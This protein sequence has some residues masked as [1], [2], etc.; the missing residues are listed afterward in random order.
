MRYQVGDIIKLDVN[1]QRI[2]QPFRL[3]CPYVR[4][5]VAYDSESEAANYPFCT[6][7]SADFRNYETGVLWRST[8][9]WL[10]MTGSVLI[11]ARESMSWVDGGDVNE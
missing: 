9:Y 1:A 2:I 4:V 8:D 5:V 6:L 7:V 3:H 10:N 11:G